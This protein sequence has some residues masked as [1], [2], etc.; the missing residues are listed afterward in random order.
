MS[1]HFLDRRISELSA[2]QRTLNSPNSSI[3]NLK[4]HWRPR[5]SPVSIPRAHVTRGDYSQ[6]SPTLL[7]A[8]DGQICIVG[9]TSTGKSTFGINQLFEIAERTVLSVQPNRAN[10]ANFENEMNIEVPSVCNVNPGVYS[11]PPYCDYIDLM[12]TSDI[13]MPGSLYVTTVENLVRYISTYS[14]LPHFTTIVLDEFHIAEN[15]MVQAYGLLS[16]MDH[17][18]EIVYASATP[19]GMNA[20][21]SIPEDVFQLK[22][23]GFV[24]SLPPDDIVDTLW[25]P[26]PY[27]DHSGTIMYLMPTANEALRLK[28]LLNIN[29]H[30]D[31]HVVT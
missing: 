21:F 28:R 8:P 10:C 31:V 9:A 25:D 6:V 7:A 15:N 22:V 3:R 11:L 26:R 20:P 24:P 23:P 18:V 12:E 2:I 16:S 30:M 4:L 5:T 17:H 14:S 27:F 1:V 19:P 13:V 29:S